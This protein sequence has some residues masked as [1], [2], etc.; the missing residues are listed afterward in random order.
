M[1]K[2]GNTHSQDNRQKFHIR[3][4]LELTLQ[5]WGWV[6]LSLIVCFALAFLYLKVT[7]TQYKR[8]ASIIVKDEKE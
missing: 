3:D 4:L 8:E 5:N 6:L 2:D 1:S 7:N